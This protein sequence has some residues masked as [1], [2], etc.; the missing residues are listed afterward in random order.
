MMLSIAII[1]GIGMI[2]NLIKTEGDYN[3]FIAAPLCISL[4][5]LNLVVFIIVLSLL[6]L[7][8]LGATYNK[9]IK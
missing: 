6:I 9:K 4:F 5:S 2:L 3:L 7:I 8:G 1:L